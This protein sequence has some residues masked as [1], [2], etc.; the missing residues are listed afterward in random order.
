MDTDSEINSEFEKEINNI[1]DSIEIDDIKTFDEINNNN[2]DIV[3]IVY[4]NFLKY[5]I[6][7]DHYQNTMKKIKNNCEYVSNLTHL[8]PYS[9]LYCIDLRE[10]YNLKLKYIGFYISINKC[11]N[12]LY[13]WNN[14]LYSINIEKCIFFKKLTDSEKA[15]IFLV[16]SIKETI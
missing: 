4:S 9:I 12:L 16:E 2:K 11:N 3:N 10:F 8:K 14:R 15:K 13:K 7:K 1:I 6:N 5:N